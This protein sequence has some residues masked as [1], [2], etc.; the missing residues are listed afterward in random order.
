MSGAVPGLRS[1]RRL[2]PGFSGLSARWSPA[3]REACWF[4]PWVRPRP[5]DVPA[6]P[7]RARMVPEPP[8]TIGATKARLL[9][10]RWLCQRGRPLSMT[11]ATCASNAVPGPATVTP[12]AA[13]RPP[14][15]PKA[16]D[17]VAGFSRRR[18]AEGSRTPKAGVAGATGRHGAVL[19]CCVGVV[20]V[21]E[22]RLL[23]PLEVDANGRAIEIGGLKQRALLAMLVLRA[24]Q[25]VP[26]D[27]LA[28]QL[29]GEHLP[30]GAQHTLEV[31]ISRLRKALGDAAGYQLVLTRPGAYLLRVQDEHV[32]VNRFERLAGKGRQALAANAPG[33]AAA[34]FRQALAL[35]RGSALAD[36]SDEPFARVEIARL[37]DLRAG[38][39]EDR[40]EADLALGHHA[41]VVGEL[42]ALVAECP[43]RERLQQQLMVALYRCGRQPEALAAYQAARRT[44]VEELGIEPSPALQRVERAILAHDAWLDP[45]P[46]AM[47][48]SARAQAGDRRRSPAGGTRRRRLLAVA[49]TSLAVTLALFMTGPSQGAGG[50][51][52]GVAGR[53]PSALSTAA[54]TSSARW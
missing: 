16:L 20:A 1:A 41:D 3:L 19:H 27:V 31:Y 39:I 9:R 44:M 53:I 13:A 18:R 51:A 30:A 33:E 24:N 25:P 42:K 35:W 48:P 2:A 36:L 40:V 12:A 38:V 15:I 10:L 7:D 14:G 11:A 34:G 47:P 6:L 45:P 21:I 37:E 43:L 29:W 8:V 26:R 52:P 49:G 5:P 32:D 23:G 22:Y 28:D 54:G 46:R 17:L 50:P 4:W